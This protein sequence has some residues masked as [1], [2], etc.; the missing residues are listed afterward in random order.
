MSGASR[1]RNLFVATAVAATVAT[2]AYAYNAPD[3]PYENIDYNGRFTFVRVRF[4]PSYWRPGN[5][6]WGLDLKWNH[7]Y[8][9]ADHHFMTML[10]DL[11]TLDVNTD[12]T[13]IL[14]L[15]DP[16]IFQYPWAYLCEVGFWTLNEVETKNLRDYLLKG[17]FLVIDDFFYGH[18]INFDE[19]IHKVLPDAKLIHI[20][21]TNPIFD[22]FFHTTPSAY[23]NPNY[24]EIQPV[25][26]AIF[27][28]N[29]PTKRIMVIVNYNNDIGEYWEWS[30]TNWVPIDLSNEAYKL[31]VDYVVYGLTH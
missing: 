10:H 8:P 29:D 12:T 21:D 30:D 25:Y 13:N 4:E 6:Q 1:A 20:D 18:W 16:K 24:A 17:G 27:E 14:S 9:R 11:T 15:D 28:D 22:S 7:D 26:Y 5:Y 2:F 19:Q 23:R 31:G 3:V